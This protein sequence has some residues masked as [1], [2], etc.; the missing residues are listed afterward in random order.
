MCCALCIIIYIANSPNIILKAIRI[1]FIVRLSFSSYVDISVKLTNFFQVKMSAISNY[2]PIPG[3]LNQNFLEKSIR[4]HSKRELVHI[5]NFNIV[6]ATAKGE[7]FASVMFR[8]N[9]DYNF[10][11]EV[12]FTAC[13]SF[14]PK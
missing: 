14:L 8:V 10:G 6:P 7:N 11:D 2:L 3:W 12:T 13:F 1:A 9:V 4:K 5:Q